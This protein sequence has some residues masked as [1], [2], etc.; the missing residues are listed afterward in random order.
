MLVANVMTWT[1]GPLAVQGEEYDMKDGLPMQFGNLIGGTTDSTVNDIYFIGGDPSTPSS[2]F[3]WNLKSKGPAEV[4][5]CSS[6][7]KFPESVIS[8]PR[9]IEFPTTLGSAF[10]YYYPPKND[11]YKCTTESAPPLLVKAHGGKF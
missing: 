1:P 6:S 11:K 2:V 4:L 5:A 8:V 7:L 3:K 10:G 9:Q